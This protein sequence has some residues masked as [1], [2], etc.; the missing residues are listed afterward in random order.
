MARA[1]GKSRRTGLTVK[2]LMQT[3]PTEDAARLWFEKHL[4]PDGPHCPPLRRNGAPRKPGSKSR[5]IA[6]GVQ[7]HFIVR[8]G[9][10]RERS[11]GSLQDWGQSPS[12]CT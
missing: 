9:T 3:F 5:P 4:W 11:K 1:P 10:I 8:V 12:T 6:A 7:R 2:E